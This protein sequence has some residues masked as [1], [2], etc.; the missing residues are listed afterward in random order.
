PSFTFHAH[1]PLTYTI[2][3]SVEEFR[4]YRCVFPEKYSCPSRMTAYFKSAFLSAALLAKLATAG[5]QVSL[6]VINMSPFPATIDFTLGEKCIK[7]DFTPSYLQNYFQSW[8]SSSLADD[9]DHDY[10]SYNDYL[11]QFKAQMGVPTLRGFEAPMTG[12]QVVPRLRIPSDGSAPTKSSYSVFTA[13][14]D[15]RIFSCKNRDSWQSFSITVQ[16]STESFTL[17]DPAADDWRLDKTDP[18]TTPLVIGP[19]G[20]SNWLPITLDT[21]TLAATIITFGYAAA[22]ASAGRAVA[23]YTAGELLALGS[24]EYFDY[25]VSKVAAELAL[26][27]AYISFGGAS[28]AGAMDVLVSADKDNRNPLKA[29]EREILRKQLDRMAMN[30]TAIYESID[31]DKRQACVMGRNWWNIYE[32]LVAGA[33]LII[34]GN[35]KAVAMPLPNVYRAWE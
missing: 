10:A 1:H 24:E 5:V 17:K 14:M 32:C 23:S 3:P 35:G 33:V 13:E 29:E 30:Y 11:Q 18:D 4:F 8:E 16:D 31:E 15:A 12:V 26:K 2:F 34:Q 21:I 25:A 27:N 6:L 7:H 9:Y 28:F 20:R 22:A 19:G